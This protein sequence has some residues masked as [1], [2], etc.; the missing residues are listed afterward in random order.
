MDSNRVI[1]KLPMKGLDIF[2]KYVPINPKT[3]RTDIFSEVCFQE[4]L[5]TRKKPP[6]HPETSFR[7]AIVAHLRA[8]DGRKP[9]SEEEEEIILTEM[10]KNEPWPCFK[11][12]GTKAKQNIGTKISLQP[13]YHEE[14]RQRRKR[15][16]ISTTPTSVNLV[17]PQSDGPKRL[18]ASTNQFPNLLPQPPVSLSSLISQ[19]SLL[20]SRPF[21]RNETSYTSILSTF[22]DVSI[23]ELQS[24]CSIRSSIIQTFSKFVSTPAPQITFPDLCGD[25]KILR[26]LRSHSFDFNSAIS[27]FEQ[28]MKWREK[29]NMNQVREKVLL[30]NP[31]IRD[32]KKNFVI[33]DQGGCY[34]IFS[35][36]PEGKV[37]DI[38]MI[39]EQT[40]K[41]KKEV[42]KAL[43][44]HLTLLEYKN[45]FFDRLSRLKRLVI[46]NHVVVDLTRVN[47]TNSWE[48]IQ[49]FDSTGFGKNIRESKIKLPETVSEA[50]SSNYNWLE[51]MKTFSWYLK[52]ILT[53][54]QSHYPNLAEKMYI[55]GSG[56]IFNIIAVNFI[57]ITVEKLTGNNFHL[58]IF[59]TLEELRNSI[60]NEEHK[61]LLPIC[62]GGTCEDIHGTEI[63]RI[64]LST[65]SRKV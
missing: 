36:L 59:S 40:E 15:P 2:K 8:K 48:S 18:R 21:V 26:L 6:K 54:Y 27:G 4:W 63:S 50:Q 44:D 62:Y 30:D 53:A 64:K 42:F 46:K 39:R 3:G 61:H 32:L 11:Q 31:S 19:F 34:P 55:V 22:E 65:L 16:F 13:G 47:D 24:V 28:M 51:T 33:G 25:V 1:M 57:S 58:N 14:L 37:L 29:Y 45:I 35:L 5:Q 56:Y 60:L 10:R 23:E 43:G 41:D 52:E 12:S 20:Q 7:K 17:S 38:W 49:E 9:F